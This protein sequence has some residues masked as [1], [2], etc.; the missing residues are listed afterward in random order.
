M[1]I[2]LFILAI[3]LL[4]ACGKSERH[5]RES[6][7]MIMAPSKQDSLFN[8]LVAVTKNGISRNE[9]RDSLAFLVLPVHASCPA[10]REKTIDSILKH[11]KDLRKGRFIIIAANG[12]RK[13]I[14]S[15]FRDR[16]SELP[17]LENRMFLDSTNHSYRYELYDKNP[18]IYYAWNKKV[19]KKITAIPATVKMDLQEFFSGNRNKKIKK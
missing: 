5:Q 15:F 4:I 19:F 10:C 9:L 12:G 17:Q 16:G 14:S 6:V 1:K 2:L 11:Q 18:A 8:N 7:E 3:V 13:T